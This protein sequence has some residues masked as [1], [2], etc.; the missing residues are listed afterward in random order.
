MENK[1]SIP[2]S[3]LNIG[4]YNVINP[5][6]YTR[7]VNPEDYKNIEHKKYIKRKFSF[8]IPLKENYK[9]FQGSLIGSVVCVKYK[10]L[11]DEEEFK[12]NITDIEHG[13]L[14]SNVPVIT[15][16]IDNL[17]LSIPKSLI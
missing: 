1:I 6:T 3:Y 10:T 14:D 4:N 7:I 16:W 15:I 13:Q 11:N 2:L 8:I 17:Y 9:T 12:G 5:Y